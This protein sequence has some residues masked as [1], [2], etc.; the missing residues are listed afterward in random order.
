MSLLSNI[1]SSSLYW[2]NCRIINC[3]HR[4]G[5]HCKRKTESKNT[6]KTI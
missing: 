4:S 5:D 6:K 1:P 2:C 3:S